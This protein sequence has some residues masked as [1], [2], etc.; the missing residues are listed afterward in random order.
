MIKH[1]ADI[2]LQGYID[3][4]TVVQTSLNIGKINYVNYFLDKGANPLL[5]DSDGRDLAYDVQEEINSG[6]LSDNGL[7][8][9]SKI[10]ERLINEFHV[11]FPLKQEKRRGIEGCIM[12]YEKLSEKGKKTLGIFAEKGYK[13]DKE[14]LSKGVNAMGEP[15][16]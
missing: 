15:L 1:G 6:R 8:A 14:N 2:N 3:G 16:E 9:Y 11:Q 5:I 13:I 10:K 7:K 12:R 4:R